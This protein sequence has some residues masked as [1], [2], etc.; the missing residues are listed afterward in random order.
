MNHFRSHLLTVVAVLSV[1][2]AG[3]AFAQPQQPAAT[4]ISVSYELVFL[5]VDGKDFQHWQTRISVSPGP[6]DVTAGVNISWKSPT[7]LKSKILPAP[8][9]KSFKAGHEYSFDAKMLPSGELTIIVTD[10]T[11][12]K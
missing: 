1:C 3:L 6:H 8:V 10:D 11:E 7:G 5:A 2:T 12:S 9:K 4:L